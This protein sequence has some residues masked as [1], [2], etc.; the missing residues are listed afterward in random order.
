MAVAP[1]GRQYP[2]SRGQQRA[3]VV[4]VGGA[5]REYS[6]AGRHVLDPFDLQARCDGAHGTPLVPWP[7]R[8]ADG[9]YHFDGADYQVALTEPTKHNAIHGFLRWRPWRVASHEPARVVMAAR[10]FPLNGYPFMLDVEVEYRLTDEGLVVTTT[11]TN[12][13]DDALPYGCGHHPYLSPGPGPGLLNEAQLELFADTRIVTDD[14][15]QL[16][17]GTDP[18][19]GSAYDF[20]VMRPIGDLKVDFAF[21]GLRRDASGRAWTRLLGTDGR[22]AELWVDEHYPYVELYTGD[23]LA[24]QRQRRGLGVEPMSCPP[25]ALQTGEKV[26][27]LEPGQSISMQ[28]G[29]RLSP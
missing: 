12:A 28:W 6:N 20:Q 29:A 1:S 19:L 3:T 16:P 17:T 18:V 4:E 8:L 2:I 26:I 13:G 24:P 5:I 25:N 11:A 15:R 7:N 21:T 23:T 10:V 9:Q 27:R 14:Q 22:M